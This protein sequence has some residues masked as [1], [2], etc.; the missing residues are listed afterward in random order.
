MFSQC[1]LTLHLFLSHQFGVTFALLRHLGA[2]FGVA[3]FLWQIVSL[4][5]CP[6]SRESISKA[7]SAYLGSFLF[8]IFGSS[9]ITLVSAGHDGTGESCSSYTIAQVK[10]DKGEALACN[11]LRGPLKAVGGKGQ[12]QLTG[13]C[14]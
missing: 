3:A 13:T 11:G 2:R 4:F 8:G 9:Q 1:T 10:M 12:S 5:F 6:F 7:I 14:G